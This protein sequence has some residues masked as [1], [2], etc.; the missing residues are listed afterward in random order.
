ME[1][2]TIKTPL[3]GLLHSILEWDKDP[4]IDYR[5]NFH[6]TFETVDGGVIVDHNCDDEGLWDAELTEVNDKSFV[7]TG[8]QGSSGF[9][10]KLQCRFD[11]NT[12]DVIGVTYQPNPKD[13]TTKE[14]EI[15]AEKLRSGEYCPNLTLVQAEFPSMELISAL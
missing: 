5:S 15:V 8:A 7:V 1:Y 3:K 2:Q 12:G 14:S 6:I 4:E 9:G 10:R 13:R 11:I